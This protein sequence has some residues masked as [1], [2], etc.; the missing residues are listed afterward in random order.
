MDA[1]RVSDKTVVAIKRLKKSRNP[2]EVE[3]VRS[4]SQLQSSDTARNHTVPIFDALDSP[5]DK[6]TTLLVMSYLVEYDK[7]PFATIGEVIEFFRQLL[8]GLRFIHG[9][10]VAHRDIM[11][12]NIMMQPS[13]YSEAPHPVIRSKSYDYKRSVKRR[14]RTERPA[15]YYYTD[16]GIACRLP[17]DVEDPPE[18]PML[19]GDRT[20]PENQHAAGPQNPYA[21]DIYCL[22]N[23]F[24]TQFLQACHLRA[25]PPDAAPLISAILQKYYDLEFL[26]PLVDAMVQQDPKARPT[27]DSACDV[28]D[29]I[30]TASPLSRLRSRAKRRGEDPIAGLYRAC[31]HVIRTAT[32]VI[33]RK[34][35][36][37]T[38]DPAVRKRFA[39]RG[40]KRTATKTATVT[41][42]TTTSATNQPAT[43]EKAP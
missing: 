21:T 43:F 29:E 35:A 9:H 37:A 28:F 13:V 36:L 16:F 6:D 2:D 1:T 5:H 3:I 39:V 12:S 24:R 25:Y 19:G 33:T 7:I 10:N 11:A 27:I 42:A 8:E 14:T 34:S 32:Y 23:T 31:R 40:S 18:E 38:P 15:K 20:V 4:F 30:L 26:A 22:G 17:P 41:S